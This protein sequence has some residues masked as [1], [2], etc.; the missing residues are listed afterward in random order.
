M[1]PD[2]DG[3]IGSWTIDGD[4]RTRLRVEHLRAT[5]AEGRWVDVEREAEELLDEEPDHAEALFL[6]GEAS[7][8]L[9]RFEVAR[10]AYASALRVDPG[11][12]R[13]ATSAALGGLALACFHVGAIPEAVEA[14]REAIRLDSERA[15]AH[16]VLSMALDFVPGRSAEALTARLVAARLEPDRYPLPA[17]RRG[18]SWEDVIAHALEHTEPRIRA[19]Y[20]KVPFR[21]EELP[22]LE[23]VRAHEPP[24]SPA[25]VALTDGTPPGPDEPAALPTGVRV[26][27]RNLERAGSVD[28]M[29]AAL[30]HDLTDEALLWLPP[31]DEA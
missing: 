22:S 16:H 18:T 23:E 14:A 25:V 1:T 5:A 29:T 17:V 12:E 6:V 20:A 26:F 10:R 19:F 28:A 2:D 4:T 13:V 11:G 3:P 15:E 9:G 21:V 31:D 24:T 27:S 8:A 7:V 30:A